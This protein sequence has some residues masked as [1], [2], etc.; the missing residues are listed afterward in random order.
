[1]AGAHRLEACRRLGY[2]EIRCTT[3][4]F[5]SLQADMAQIDE[6]LVRNELSALERSE[7]ISKRKTIYESIHPVT[8]QGAAKKPKGGT[9]K[10]EKVASFVDDTSKKTGMSSRVIQLDAQVI[11]GLPKDLRDRIRKTD[12]ADNRSEL[13]KLGKIKDPEEQRRVV[14]MVLDKKAKNVEDA[15]RRERLRV[16]HDEFLTKNAENAHLEAGEGPAVYPIILADVPFRYKRSL[17]NSRDISNQYD[18]MPTEE[19]A[20]IPV[21]DVAAQDCICFFWC[22]SSK[23]AEACEILHRWGFE[24]R[25]SMVWV[26]PSIGPGIWARIS[27]E[28][29]IIGVKG[30]PP[31]ACEANKPHSVIEAPRGE[32]SEKPD[33]LHL[34]IEKGWP[35]CS[36]LELFARKRRKGWRCLG[37]EIDGS[38]ISVAIAS[39][40]ARAGMSMEARVPPA[41]SAPSASEPAQDSATAP[42]APP[43]GQ[44]R[45]EAEEAKDVAAKEKQWLIDKGFKPVVEGS[46]S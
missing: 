30:N 45:K 19:I 33:A 38:D 36:K 40:V 24:V 16:R 35:T 20:D 22:G 39:V 14:T 12:L 29:V 8:K 11:K 23:I 10:D 15:L 42:T 25:S 9:P 27:H 43:A 7:A 6:N 31:P 4:S 2:E 21:G 18:D 13:L 3:R 46:A 37:N 34:A 28:L 41:S 17:S 44:T 26:K 5:D 32:H 1:V